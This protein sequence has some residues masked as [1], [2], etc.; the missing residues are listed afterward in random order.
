M[1][2]RKPTRIELKLDDIEEWNDLRR[3]S[4]DNQKANNNHTPFAATSNSDK[5]PFDA[6]K[7]EKREVIHQR[8]GYSPR[9]VVEPTTNIATSQQ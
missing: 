4:S 8:I 5:I 3:A 7:K 6:S 9:P 2:R 1:L